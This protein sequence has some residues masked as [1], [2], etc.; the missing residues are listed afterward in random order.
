M[1][2]PDLNALATEIYAQNVAVGWWDNW[3]DRRSRFP[4]AMILVVSEL[5][6]ALEGDRKNLMDDKLPEHP[7]F[8]VEL[9]DAVIRLLD[10]AGALGVDVNADSWPVEGGTVPE[11]IWSILAWVS[12]IGASEPYEN[13]CLQRFLGSII[14][15]AAMHEVDLWGIVSKKREYNRTR[16]DHTR[17][18]RSNVNGKAY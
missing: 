7:M 6:E 14:R 8:E 12:G 2:S 3:P 9:A 4:T 17:E 15:L 5:I 10:L 1:N 13:Q 18:A 16:A 11:Q